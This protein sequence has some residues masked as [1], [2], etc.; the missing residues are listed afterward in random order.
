MTSYSYHVAQT[1]QKN[2]QTME[3]KDACYCEESFI[4]RSYLV[5]EILRGG[6]KSKKPMV[7]RVKVVIVNYTLFLVPPSLCRKFNSALSLNYISERC[8]G[9]IS[10]T[11]ANKNV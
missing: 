1:K 5:L 7:N 2:K 9:A 8:F 6:A 3:T 10:F 11:L 4:D